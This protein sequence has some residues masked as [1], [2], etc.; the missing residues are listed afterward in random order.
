MVGTS[1]PAFTSTTGRKKGDDHDDA[2]VRPRR[3]QPSTAP[4]ATPLA[5]NPDAQAERAAQE[6]ELGPAA[7]QAVAELRQS[8]VAITQRLGQQDQR[9]DRMSQ[10]LDDL[11][12]GLASIGPVLQQ[13][14]A[15][16]HAPRGGTASGNDA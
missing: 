7:A 1:S 11:K 15:I 3:E 8:Q 14:S 12:E 10:K 9:A 5:K 4:K 6:A 2:A 13:L 16:L